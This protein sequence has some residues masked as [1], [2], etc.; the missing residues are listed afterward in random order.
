[1]SAV[2]AAPSVMLIK[3]DLLQLKKFNLSVTNALL[4]RPGCKRE[5]NWAKQRKFS[6]LAKI[7]YHVIY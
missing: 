7:D 2:L 3:K 6:L 1:M 5:G 4:K